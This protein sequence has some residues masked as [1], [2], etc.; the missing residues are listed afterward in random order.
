MS[1]HSFI[2]HLPN[3]LPTERLANTKVAAP[4]VTQTA[5]GQKQKLSDVLVAINSIL[6]IPLNW[7]NKKWTVDSE[8][9]NKAVS[10]PPPS[11]IK[12]CQLLNLAVC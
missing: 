12:I 5:I 3:S 2:R 9:D 7:Q 8:C 4:E 10:S 1:F 11:V 6:N